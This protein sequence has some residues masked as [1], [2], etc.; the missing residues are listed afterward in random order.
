MVSSFP[1]TSPGRGGFYS[2]YP[3]HPWVM[4][5]SVPTAFMACGGLCQWPLVDRGRR[6]SISSNRLRPTSPCMSAGSRPRTTVRCSLLTRWTNATSAPSNRARH[7]SSPQVSAL[8][9]CCI[10]TTG[11]YPGKAGPGCLPPYPGTGPVC[12]QLR[13]HLL[14]ESPCIL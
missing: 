5:S 11:V 10:P 13:G 7:S 12:S 8:A 3:Q 9:P 14:A 4:A 6:S 1:T 2:P